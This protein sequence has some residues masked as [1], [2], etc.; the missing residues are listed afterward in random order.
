[1]ADLLATTRKKPSELQATIESN[2]KS[3]S[4]PLRD[5]HVVT[6]SSAVTSITTARV[7]IAVRTTTVPAPRRRSNVDQFRRTFENIEVISFPLV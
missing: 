6:F 7:F 2:L 3:L 4:A 1:M 5:L